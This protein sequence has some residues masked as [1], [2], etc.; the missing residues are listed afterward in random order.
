LKDALAMSNLKWSTIGIALV[1]V[2]LALKSQGRGGR[3]VRLQRQTIALHHEHGT[4]MNHGS[5]TTDPQR[6]LLSTRG[7]FI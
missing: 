5:E 2:A 1:P 3:A 6:N 7:G 4:P